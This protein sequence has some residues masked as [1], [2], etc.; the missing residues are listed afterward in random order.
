M[1]C[2]QVSA[3]HISAI[4]RFACRENLRAG[5]LGNPGRYGYTPGQEQEAFE[6][7][8]TANRKSVESRYHEELDQSV[9]TYNPDAITLRPIEVLKAIDGLAYQ[10]DEWDGF[11]AST[12]NAILKGIREHAIGKLPGYGAAAWSIA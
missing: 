3:N 11:E 7:L 4:V 12:A 6:L 5:W 9:G 1:S 2:Y 8:E 10:C